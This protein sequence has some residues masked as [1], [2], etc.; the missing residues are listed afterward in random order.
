[1]DFG[2]LTLDGL[3]DTGALSKAIHEADLL[4]LSLL[5][6]QIIVKRT[7]LPISK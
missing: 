6:P 7:Q 1:M 2:E 4:K 5:A 3:V